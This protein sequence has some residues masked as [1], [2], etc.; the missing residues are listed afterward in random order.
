MAE[1]IAPHVSVIVPT[2]CEGE[3]LPL[4]VPRIARALAG[5]SYEVVVVDDDSPDGTAEICAD[6]ARTY[7]VKL[8]VR[9]EAR[10]GLSGAV[11]TGMAMAG[12]DILA[13]MDADLQHP[14]ESL[15]ALIAPLES[16]EAEFVLGS[17]HLPSAGTDEGW[18]PLR[19]L[20]SWG[21]AFL[22]RPFARHTSDPMSG[23]F[24]LSRSTYERAERLTPIGYKIG[25]ELMCKGRVQRIA[26]VPIHFGVRARGESKLT[27]VQ[28]FRYLEHLS[29]LYD[30]YFPRASPIAKF[31]I[32]I[33][34]SWGL[35]AAAFAFLRGLADPVVSAVLSYPVA[36]AVTAVFHARHVRIQREFLVTKHPWRDFAAI[37]AVE[38]AACAAVAAWAHFR[39][40][41][42]SAAEVL[43]LGFGAA[44]V[45]RYVLRKE[46]LQDIRGL[47][48]EPR[49]DEIGPPRA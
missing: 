6:L 23:F 7:P 39:L 49:R 29:R 28:Q 17:R 9:K 4:L 44:T 40:R 20:N 48:R 46:L 32:V 8:F 2:L 31:L 14:P 21:A 3:N 38:W 13:V 37:A 34:C 26:E 36:L 18:G 5:R 12:G 30:F 27:L 25:L 42:A 47:R 33:A 1:L 43:I 22:A 10:D 41:Q 24:A 15:P 45:V 35:A 19:R 16:G 11:L